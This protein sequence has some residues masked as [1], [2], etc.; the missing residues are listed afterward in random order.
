[1][2]KKKGGE[3]PIPNGKILRMCLQTG[4]WAPKDQKATIKK[5]EEAD[6]FYLQANNLAHQCFMDIAAMR[7]LFQK[8][9]TWVL[10]EISA[11]RVSVFMINWASPSS[12]VLRMRC[13]GGLM[14]N[15][16]ALQ[17]RSPDVRKVNILYWTVNMPA[18]A[19]KRDTII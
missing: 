6:A 4:F 2:R 3:S 19:I 10:T 18:P 12:S 16:I 13:K 11:H 15:F 5:C 8:Q 14:T 17:K 9:K 7:L 1:M